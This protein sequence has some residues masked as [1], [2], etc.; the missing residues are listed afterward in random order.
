MGC[1]YGKNKLD[2]P[3]SYSL[4][5]VSSLFVLSQIVTICIDTVEHLWIASSSLGFA[6]GSTYSLFATMCIEWFGLRRFCRLY[7]GKRV[8]IAALAHFSENWGYLSVAPLAAGNVFSLMFGRNLDAHETHPRLPD[9]RNGISH[10]AAIPPRC[11]L[12]KECYVDT[13]YVTAVAC[14][15]AVL[16]SF[17]ACW[18]DRKKTRMTGGV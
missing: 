4:V 10:A 6:Y 8:L 2:I 15:V 7:V 16:L 3:R 11:M 9:W 18:K 13:V 14:S 17:W 5:L 12:G 1:D